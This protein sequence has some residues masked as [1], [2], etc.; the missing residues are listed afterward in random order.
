MDVK[1]ANKNKKVPTFIDETVFFSF[2]SYTC[3]ALRHGMTTSLGLGS[4]ANSLTNPPPP[5]AS[6]DSISTLFQ[7]QL[8]PADIMQG[9]GS[10]LAPQS[11]FENHCL[12][13]G[14]C[15]SSHAFPRPQPPPTFPQSFFRGPCLIV[16]G[17]LK[18]S[19][20]LS[21]LKRLGNENTSQSSYNVQ[22]F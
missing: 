12:R 13:T 10:F 5:I 22:V 16:R 3:V 17:I 20:L 7:R 19:F 11:P 21:C 9:L 2:F 15:I 6:T 18:S 4:G 8:C 1:Q 14:R